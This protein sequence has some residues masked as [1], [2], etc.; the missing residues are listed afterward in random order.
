MPERK[1]TDASYIHRL[2][3][4]FVPP[5]EYYNKGIQESD[6]LGQRPINKVGYSLYFD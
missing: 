4:P 5:N 6:N 1:V 2:A 3:V